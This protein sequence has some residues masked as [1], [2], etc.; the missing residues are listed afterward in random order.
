M[1]F[2]DLKVTARDGSEVSMKDYENK[3]VLVV[4]TA[5]GCGFTPHY[6]PLEE[7][8]EKYHDRGFEIIDVPCNQF[9]GQTPGTDDEIH[10][11][12]TLKYNTQFPQMKKSDVNGE[13]AI[14]LFK[15]LKSQK[16]FEGFGKG[17]AALAM[18]AM[19]KKIDKDYK[20]N[21]EIK[22]NFTKFIVNR[23]G[24]VVARFEPTADMKDVDKFVENLINE[25]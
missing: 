15:Y 9:A 3:V 18:S 24:E 8:Y 20:N 11:F 16:T 6:K 5:T 14:E 21:S 2:Y 25:G 19:L 12:C 1:G 10:E 13:N 23:K 7:M 4:N 22:W 17:P